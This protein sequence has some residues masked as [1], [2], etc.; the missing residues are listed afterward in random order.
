MDELSSE[1]GARLQFCVVIHRIARHADPLR[2]WLDDFLN[3][4]AQESI[5]IA[6]AERNVINLSKRTMSVDSDKELKFQ[7][8]VA[9]EI[10][11]G[12]VRCAL[13]LA[14]G[15]REGLTEPTTVQAAY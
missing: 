1:E 3:R 2:W 8:L 6:K 10:K 5:L 13:S 15:S 14:L 9:R 12:D 7:Y 4:F 11:V